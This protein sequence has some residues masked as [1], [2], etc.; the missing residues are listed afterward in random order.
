M[1]NPNCGDY[2]G[3]FEKIVVF[4]DD[5]TRN[6]SIPRV[7]EL[8]QKNALLAQSLKPYMLPKTLEKWTKTADAMAR[9]VSKQM[10][11]SWGSA[12]S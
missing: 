9:W 6:A 8:L 12:S 5:Y 11:R 1:I 10:D 7:C 2:S 4:G 3:V